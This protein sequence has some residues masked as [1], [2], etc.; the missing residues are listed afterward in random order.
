MR[1]AGV[2]ETCLYASDLDAIEQFYTTVLG[3]EVFARVE[4]RHVF[5]RCGHGVFLV[6]NPDRTS[7]EQSW[8]AEVPVPLHGT[9]GPGHMAFAVAD[10]EIPA[11]RRRLEQLGVTIEAD[12]PW[13]RGGRSLYF[14]DPAGN[15]I[16]LASPRIWGL[17]E[18]D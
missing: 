13:P 15:S 14:R 6:F 8:V 11:W 17:S 18:R 4:G 1:I 16:E 7:N 10:S 3:L 9:Y 5:F 12:I 2:L